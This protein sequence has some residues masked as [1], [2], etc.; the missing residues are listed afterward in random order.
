MVPLNSLA[1]RTTWLRS[2]LRGGVDI[3][4]ILSN[5][6]NHPTKELHW[7]FAFELVKMMFEKEGNKSNDKTKRY[8]IKKKNTY[9]ST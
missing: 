8:I 4:S 7:L 5:K 1:H 3:T 6:I 9:A 2:D